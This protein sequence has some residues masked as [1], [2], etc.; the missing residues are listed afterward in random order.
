MTI[1]LRRALSYYLAVLT[2]AAPCLC[3]CTFGR[4]LA[5]EPVQ[6]AEPQPPPCC[7]HENPIQSD[8]APTPSAPDSQDRCPCRDH[9]E[10]QAFAG[11]AAD[12]G[13]LRSLSL[14]LNF[15]APAI[16]TAMSAPSLAAEFNGPHSW[17]EPFPSSGDLLFVHHRLRC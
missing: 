6:P 10:K 15:D 4:A 14:A 17:R 9:A 13:L 3:C 2:V 1:M 11:P 12:L 5:A 7:C 16:V 8:P